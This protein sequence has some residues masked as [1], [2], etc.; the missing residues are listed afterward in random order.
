[1]MAEFMRPLREGA[2]AKDYCR[3]SATRSVGKTI[4]QGHQYLPKVRGNK[5]KSMLTTVTQV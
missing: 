2:P 5:T 4:N 1:M 3:R